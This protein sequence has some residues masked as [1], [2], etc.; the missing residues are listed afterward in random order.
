MKTFCNIIACLT[1]P[2]HSVNCSVLP[3]YLLNYTYLVLQLL[4]FPAS[5]YFVLYTTY[6]LSTICHRSARNL[7]L[8]YNVTCQ[9]CSIYSISAGFLVGLSTNSLLRPWEGRM[10]IDDGGDINQLSLGQDLTPMT[11]RF[12]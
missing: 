3:H 10:F 12:Q 4:S 11:R 8:H 2:H 5:I 7:K 1:R 6:L 9:F